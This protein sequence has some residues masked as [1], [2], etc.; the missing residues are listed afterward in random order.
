MAL[1]AVDFYKSMTT[2]H[3][4]T[5]WQDV[6]RPVL[7]GVEAYVKVQILDDNTVV[8]SFKAAEEI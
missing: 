6:Y 7:N 3:D 2:L 1:D 4:S 8:I 5:R